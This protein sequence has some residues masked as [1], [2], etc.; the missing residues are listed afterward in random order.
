MPTQER[1]IEMGRPISELYDEHMALEFVE[2]DADGAAATMTA[3]VHIDLVPVMRGGRGNE[4]VRL[5]YAKEFIPNQPPDFAIATVS[6]T[7]GDNQLVDEL[8]ASFTHTIE[9]PWMLPGVPPT[10]R[11]VEIPLIVIIG[12]RDDKIAHEHI[13]WDQASVLKQVGLLTDSALP[14]FGAETAERL[15]ELSQVAVQSGRAS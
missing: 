11:R 10:N 13:Y 8:I 6:R 15:K 12:F 7:V 1:G 14:S 4:E 3:D 9:M 5:F 2:H